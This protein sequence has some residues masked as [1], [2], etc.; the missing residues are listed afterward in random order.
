MSTV[1]AI[2]VHSRDWAM[3]R[4]HIEEL[5]ETA[6][7]KLENFELNQEQTAVQRGKIQAFRELLAIE[8]RVNRRNPQALS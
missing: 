3:L 1:P 5:I 6:R 8:Q 7:T 2:D 4:S